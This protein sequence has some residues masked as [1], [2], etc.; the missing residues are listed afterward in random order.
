MS[1]FVERN[2]LSLNER[3]YW[4]KPSKKHGTTKSIIYTASLKIE[5]LLL[6]NPHLIVLD[7]TTG[8]NTRT[9]IYN[10]N[11]EKSVCIS[12]HSDNFKKMENLW[13]NQITEII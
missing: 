8:K 7:D 13:F 2:Y 3:N 9:S 1:T 12:Y 4:V 5:A 10:L 6:S 11:K